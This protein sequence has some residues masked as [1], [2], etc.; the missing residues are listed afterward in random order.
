MKIPKIIHVPFLHNNVGAGVNIKSFPLQFSGKSLEKEFK[1]VFPEYVYEVGKDQNGNQN[2]DQS[3]W[4]KL[5]GLAE[6]I[7]A[8][9]NSVMWAW[10]YYKGS[11]EFAYY[12]HDK[13]GEV[14]YPKVPSLSI[15]IV[16]GEWV[17]PRY[18]ELNFEFRITITKSG[19]PL[20]SV[21]ESD[22]KVDSYLILLAQKLPILKF[23]RVINAWFGGTSTPNTTIKIY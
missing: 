5:F 2:D 21:R 15:K 9:V 12:S 20:F 6:G 18:T 10:R 22:N 1:F 11:L 19:D 8:R 7:D 4:N 17:D 3:D 14:S 16:N 13:N 23:Y